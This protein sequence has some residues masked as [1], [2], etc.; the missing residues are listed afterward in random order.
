[1][2][3]LVNV[4]YYVVEAKDLAA[5]RTFAED[6]VGLQIGE[7]G[8][9]GALSLRADDYAQRLLIEQGDADDVVAIGWELASEADLHG[10]VEGLRAK[11]VE[12]QD[13]SALA[14]SRKVAALFSCEDPN[15]LRHEFF[16]GAEHAPEGSQFRS[17]VL[18]GHF[19]TGRFGIG[20]VVVMAKDPGA[21]KSV[22]FY[23]ETL[24]L[25]ISDYATEELAPGFVVDA[26]FMHAA[27]GRHHSLA[28][29]FG[30]P[31]KRVNHILLE[32]DNMHDVGAGY[33]RFLANKV[34]IIATLGFHGADTM[35]SFY[36]QTPSGFGIEIGWGAI[37]ITDPEWKASRYNKLSDWGHKRPDTMQFAPAQ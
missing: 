14:A 29:A 9:D 13:R 37:E 21:Q 11:G 25:A 28:V 18:Q 27:G 12:V 15:G 2:P 36:A 3:K 10:Y 7:A 32:V 17:K 4:G 22:Q 23:H 6:V 5:W 20:H 30:P 33:D 26:T 1:M 16:T 19:K 31:G 24:G 34:P 8:Q 35:M